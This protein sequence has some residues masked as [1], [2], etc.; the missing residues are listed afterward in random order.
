LA[1][2]AGKMS[3]RLE[4]YNALED[5]NDDK[6]KQKFKILIVKTVIRALENYKLLLK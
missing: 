1:I 2:I 3:E 4:Y 5:V 6:T